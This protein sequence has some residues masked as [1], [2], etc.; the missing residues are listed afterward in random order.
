M[1]VS[2][3][4]KAVVRW[5]VLETGMPVYSDP[6]PLREAWQAHKR[7]MEG[8]SL[9]S[10]YREGTPEFQAAG[11]AVTPFEINASTSGA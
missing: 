6:M 8:C 7:G 2:V 1:V 11:A 3:V 4:K 10:V 9:G 5:Y